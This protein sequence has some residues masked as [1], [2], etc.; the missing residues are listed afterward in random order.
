MEII[1]VDGHTLREAA[2]IHAE[3]W[4]ASHRAFCSAEF[5][6]RHTPSRQE[7]YLKGKL[8]ACAKLF[9]LVAGKPVGI[10]SV[11]GS[12]IEDLYVLPSSQNQGFGA[13][14]LRHA[15][16]ECAGVPTLWTLENNDSAARFYGRNGF[17]PTGRRNVVAGRLGE[18]EFALTDKPKAEQLFSGRTDNL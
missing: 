7:A 18:I 2:A 4:Q 8:D 11:T 10:V 3:S 17:A 14:L 6:A 1:Q 16:S 9:M 12:L 13:V 5:V 15:V